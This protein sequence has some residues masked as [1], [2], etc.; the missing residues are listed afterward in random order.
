MKKNKTKK[1]I[2]K[3]SN[4]SR[5][6]ELVIR[7]APQTNFPTPV[8]ESDLMP[9]KSGSKYMI[10]KTWMSESQVLRILQKTPPQHI[11]RRPGKGGK[12]FDYVSG[13]YVTKV[14]NFIFGWNWDFEIMSTEEKYGQ[15]IARGKLTVKDNKGHSIIKMQS[16]RADIKFK[17][18]TKI[19]LDYGN[20]EKAAT[21][22]ALKKCASLLGIASDIY[23]K[24]EFKEIGREVQPDYS[25]QPKDPKEIVIDT[26]DSQEV[27]MKEGQVKGPD[28][29]P[30][31][32]CSAC[33]DPISEQ[34]AEY[35]LK[36]FG[37]R[38][39]REDQPNNN[40]K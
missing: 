10:P 16:G 3:V 9:E 38:L 4:R 26:S 24:S 1:K 13:V 19:P 39:C 28:G 18:D 25:S 23:G 6:N 15:I 8:T 21:T 27:E 20:D 17:K 40:K 11:L 12:D 7:V 36:V 29:E 33:G 22:D 37:K 35:S 30:T 31:Y 2:K 14:L 34:A 5:S 32:I